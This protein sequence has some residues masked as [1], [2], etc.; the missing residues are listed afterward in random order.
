MPS[1]T[2]CSVTLEE[3]ENI[4]TSTTKDADIKYAARAVLRDL[5]EHPDRYTII[6]FTNSM[7][8]PINEKDLPITNDTKI[9]ACALS[10]AETE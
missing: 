5:D 9:L 2:I 3:L 10:I 7:L 6:V 1:M 4:K 8:A